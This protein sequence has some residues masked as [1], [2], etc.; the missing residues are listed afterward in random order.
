MW[1]WM[2]K[3]WIWD[4]GE[5]SHRHI[6]FS[7]R[8]VLD[9]RLVGVSLEGHNLMGSTQSFCCCCCCSYTV[10]GSSCCCCCFCLSTH[11]RWTRVLRKSIH[12]ICRS[13]DPSAFSS[14][15]WHRSLRR[16]SSCALISS[17]TGKPN[18]HQSQLSTIEHNTHNVDSTNFTNI[19]V[20]IPRISKRKLN[21]QQNNK[22]LSYCYSTYIIYNLSEFK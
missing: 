17:A 18:Q 10:A 5:S 21:L 4:L 19:I 13:S 9:L 22:R 11:S 16:A 8:V 7:P 6:V 1:I 20:K 12:V 14:G 2:L 3:I 15:E